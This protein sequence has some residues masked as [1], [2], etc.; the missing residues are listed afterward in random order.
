[1]YQV[2]GKVFAQGQPLD[3]QS[4]CGSILVENFEEVFSLFRENNIQNFLI[5][6]VEVK[7]CL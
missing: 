1:M 3:I 4:I 6:L 5:T 2:I 7:E